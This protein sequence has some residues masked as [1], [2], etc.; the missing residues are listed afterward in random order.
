MTWNWVNKTEMEM[1]CVHAGRKQKVLLLSQHAP[2][3]A[4][5][6]Q[7]RPG[8]HR[9]PGGLHGRRR[10]NLTPLQG[11]V[12]RHAASGS[13]RL[14]ARWPCGCSVHTVQEVPVSAEK[15]SKTCNPSHETVPAIPRAPKK[16]QPTNQN[17]NFSSV[18]HF[19]LPFVFSVF[20]LKVFSLSR[21]IIDDENLVY[22]TTVSKI[23]K[24]WGTRM[25]QL[26]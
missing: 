4:P 3:K 24:K 15:L 12:L 10:G 2:S 6:C 14:R 21:E 1:I 25:A 7:H 26:S 18:D 19:P 8:H 16:N 9:E 23:E 5:P 11:V 17:Q 22:F 13:W 20:H